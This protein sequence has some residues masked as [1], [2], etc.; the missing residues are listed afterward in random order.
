M[1]IELKFIYSE[2]G[3]CTQQSAAQQNKQSLLRSRSYEFLNTKH[4]NSL[5]KIKTL[6]PFFLRASL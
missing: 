2:I 4:E 5:E 3:I 1:K 6:I